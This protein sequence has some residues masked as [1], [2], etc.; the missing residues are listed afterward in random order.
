MS[1]PALRMPDNCQALP[2]CSSPLERLG[3]WWGRLMAHEREALCVLGQVPVAR[4]Q[5][6]ELAGLSDAEQ[7]AL[8]NAIKGGG[9]LCGLVMQE[10]WL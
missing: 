3:L 2:V 4:A 7:A 5:A 8:L 6:A 9:V 1:A 10:C